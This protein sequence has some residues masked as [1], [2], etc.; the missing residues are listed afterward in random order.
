MPVWLQDLK[1]HVAVAIRSVGVG[2]M[3]VAWTSSLTAPAPV[4]ADFRVFLILAAAL[5]GIVASQLLT[6]RPPSLSARV[7]LQPYEKDLVAV[8]KAQAPSD[9]QRLL[10]ALAR[11]VVRTFRVRGA[12]PADHRTW[13]GL[14]ARTLTR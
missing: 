12:L 8:A 11:Y 1:F 6:G 5:V 14:V 9:P 4:P 3:A 10:D 2:L 13:L 7:L